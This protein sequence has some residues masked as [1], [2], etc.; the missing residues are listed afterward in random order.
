MH[1][2]PEQL[3]DAAAV[4][5]RMAAGVAEL[6]AVHAR[7]AAAGLTG[8]AVGAALGESDPVSVQAKGVMASRFTSLSSSLTRIVRDFQDSDFENA[9]QIAARLDAG[10]G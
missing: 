8:S 10:R 5:D 2:S 3:R 1:L 9:A 6:P 7:E 4:F